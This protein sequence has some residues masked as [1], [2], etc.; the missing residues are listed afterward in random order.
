MKK[1][2]LAL[3]AVA[4]LTTSVVFAQ[5]MRTPPDPATMVQ[6]HVDH[7]T[8]ALSLTP[9]QQQQ[10]TT[11]LTG[12]MQGQ[13]ANHDQLKA[14]HA[15]LKAAVQKNDAAG[16]EQAATT[17]GNLTAQG[18]AAHAKSQAAFLQILTPDQQAK[19]NAMDMGEGMHGHGGPGGPGMHGGMHDGPPPSNQ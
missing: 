3:T 6:H 16:I 2:I 8:K 5:H 7:M 18:I 1:Y 17:I 11:M 12:L 9:A 10:A 15:S 4:A 14:A 19:F 13:Q